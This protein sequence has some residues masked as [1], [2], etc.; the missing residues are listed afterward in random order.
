MDTVL[1][2]TSIP[3]AAVTPVLKDEVGMPIVTQKM[4]G[5]IPEEPQHHQ[6]KHQ[7]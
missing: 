3:T 6:R 5:D 1:I 7:A 4:R 2:E